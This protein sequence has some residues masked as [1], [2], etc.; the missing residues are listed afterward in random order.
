MQDLDIIESVLQILNAPPDQDSAVRE[1][2]RGR[3]TTDV[4]QSPALVQGRPVADWV[5][6]VEIGGLTVSGAS[7]VLD[8]AGPQIMPQLSRLLREDESP[9]I[10][11][12]AAWAISLIGYHNPS[13]PEVH[14]TVP[15]LTTAA[16]NKNSE[17]RIYSVQ[18]LGAIGR[19]ASNAIPVLIQLTRDQSDGVRISAVDALGRI[20]ATSPESV[21]ALTAAASDASSDVRIT[22]RKALEIV[23]SGKA[24]TLMTPDEARS[25]AERLANEKAQALYNCQPF[26]NGPP[27][28]FVR[29]HWTW[30]CLQGR[31]QSDMEATVEFAADGA[32]PRVT[33]LWL[34]SRPSQRV[35]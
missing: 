5:K 2:N 19:A 13:A 26:R 15:V 6:E 9:E 23:R 10:Q 34:E 20:G 11:A 24:S 7:K 8:D 33:V 16:E 30:R 32:E 22:A 28:R 27:A 12:K 1:S 17:V 25:L 29:D 3:H 21:A 31:G 4:P 18:A 14:N 35:P